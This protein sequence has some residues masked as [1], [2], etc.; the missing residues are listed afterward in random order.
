MSLKDLWVV[1]IIYK[2]NQLV[3]T[4]FLVFFDSIFVSV[5]CVKLFSFFSFFLILSNML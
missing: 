1:Y 4:S 3:L 2:I 5:S